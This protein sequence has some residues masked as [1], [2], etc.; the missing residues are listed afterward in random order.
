M[1]IDGVPTEIVIDDLFPYDSHKEKWAFAH[2]NQKEIWVQ[3]LEKA[4]SK[5]YGSYQRIEAGDIREAFPALT[6]APAE[7]LEHK[8]Y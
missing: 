2:T 7:M 4:W 1:M 3:L 5:V 6:G 8:D